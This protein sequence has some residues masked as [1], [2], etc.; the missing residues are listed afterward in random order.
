MLGK[1]K[2]RAATFAAGR[3]VGRW[4]FGSLAG[5]GTVVLLLSACGNG[6]TTPPI[7]NSGGA[8]FASAA[9][10]PLQATNA[11]PAP[12]PLPQTASASGLRITL[13]SGARSG[14]Q[15]VLT[16]KIESADPNQPNMWTVGGGGEIAGI[17]G[18]END[19][20]GTGLRWDSRNQVAQG[21]QPLVPPGFKP[22]PP[23]PSPTPQPTLDITGYLETIPF[24]LS[25]AADRPVTVTVQRVRFDTV[26]PARPPGKVIS[27]DWS[28]AFVPASLP[29]QSPTSTSVSD[30][31]ATT[32][33]QTAATAPAIPSPAADGGYYK[34]TFAQAQQL[35]PFT[36]IKP[37]FIPP[38]LDEDGLT[39][40]I[41]PVPPV[42]S[43]TGTPT[44]ANLSY[45]AAGNNGLNVDIEETSLDLTPPGSS[46]SG[47]SSTAMSAVA[48]GGTSVTRIKVP[49]QHGNSS[50]TYVWKQGTTTIMLTALISNPASA[51]DI[52]HMIASMI[53]QGS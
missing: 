44:G 21:I 18:P 4:R 38:S 2:G 11:S 30:S 22:P 52:E 47:A 48:I 40:M 6:S 19:V 25:E 14:N 17:L 26:P 50:V 10:T 16:F 53:A 36:L 8:A 33:S 28:F 3:S 31:R 42:G 12:G 49:D 5:I 41:P 45:P 51:Q 35:T 46:G 29:P 32:Q 23:A 1:S 43:P 15:L 20:Q 7:G 34:L 37:T 13:I 9:A 27:G 39:I 24:V